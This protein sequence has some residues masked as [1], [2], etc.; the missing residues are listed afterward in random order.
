MHFYTK[1]TARYFRSRKGFVSVVSGFSLMGIL[2][3]V[4]ALIVVMSVMNGF[5]AELLSRILGLGGH[6]T[7]V[8]SGASASETEVARQNLLKHPS[9]T[10]AEVYVQG[11]ALV[12]GRGTASGALIR[13]V[14]IE[15]TDNFVKKYRQSG[16]MDD[17]KKK[18]H[19]A[20]GAGLA[21]KL[22][23]TVGSVV[24]L[25]SPQGSTTPFGF[26]PRMQKYKVAAIF[27]AGMQLY[28]NSWVYMS[29]ASAQ[30]FF[31]LGDRVT[32]VDLRVDNPMALNDIRDDIIKASGSENA[33]ILSWLDNNRQFFQALQVERVAMF[34]ILSLIVVV[35]A[36]NIITGQTMTVNDK[37][38]D[39]AILRTM[40]AR[41]RDILMVFFMNGTLIGVLGTVLG[42]AIGLL[43]VYN[44]GFIVG[45]LEAVFGVSLFSGGAYFLDELPAVI[46]WVDV[47]VITITSLVLSMLASVYPAWRAS[48]LNPVEVLRNE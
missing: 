17:L 21:R 38:S 47:S 23:A 48:R 7:Y 13:G 22:N 6:G 30:K 33:Y 18:N 10:S 32:G 46:N 34:I 29:T 39:I 36:F 3:G 35:A 9:V 16:Y 42:V 31:A 44:L 15:N 5:R 41:R 2:L 25:I 8:I 26:M 28:D 12:M 40:G 45:L 27:K 20:I 43:I 4:A 37:K 24:T 14:D 19:I 1:L 11:Q